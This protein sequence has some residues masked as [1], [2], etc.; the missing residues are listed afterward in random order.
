MPFYNEAT[1]KEVSLVSN[2]VK[3]SFERYERKYFLTPAQYRLFKER[4]NLFVKP[5]DY[6]TYTLC[7]IYYDT[8][9]YRLIRAS[10]EKP[11]Y[12]EKLRVRSYGVPNADSK[13]FV[14]LKK[15]YDGVVYKRRITATPL[16]ARSLLNGFKEAE[17]TSQISNEISYFQQFY[18]AQ[19]KVF[20]AY[21]REA[22]KGLDDADLRITFDTNMRFRL[23]NLSLQAGDYGEP[24]IETDRI[25]MEIKIPGVC[26][27]WLS[28]MLSEFKIYPTS[29]SKYGECYKRHILNNNKKSLQRRRF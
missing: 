9:D 24:I 17:Q 15:K 2:T 12:K 23:D 19:P 21:D 11:M 16:I 29:F 3:Q 4:L 22:Y 5:D 8:D 26:P 6:P 20:I 25:L 7:N 27:L 28:R 10:L 13:I 1:T 18:R 14:E